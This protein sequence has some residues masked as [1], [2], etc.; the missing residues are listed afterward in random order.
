MMKKILLIFLIHFGA[1]CQ[2]FDF[3]TINQENGLPSSTVFS[4]TQDSRDLIWIGTDGAG[5]VRYDGKN[6]KIINK[7]DTHEGLFITDVVEDSNKNMIVATKYTG[8]MVY[9]GQRFIK[10]FDRNNSKLTGSF[11]QT[12]FPTSKGVYCFTDN[13]IVLLKKDYSHEMLLN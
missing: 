8:L 4:I 12:L 2:V 1:Y 10:Y 5:L 7:T 6:F 11:V 13:E 3:E 9:D